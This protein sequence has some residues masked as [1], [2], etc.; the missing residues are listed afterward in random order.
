MKA[1][2]VTHGRYLDHDTGYGH[3]ERPARLEAVLSGVRY[4][5]VDG[6]VIPIEPRP[7]TRA[8]LERV[9][10]SR[11]LYAIE[12]FCRGGGGSIDAD[13]TVGGPSSW[14]AAAVGWT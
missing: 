9:H 11:Y 6:A 2:L 10:P 7:A 3:P 14:E 1:L 8:D 4:A 12:R 5:G 13:T